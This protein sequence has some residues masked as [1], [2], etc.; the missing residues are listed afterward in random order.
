MVKVRQSMTAM[1]T[2][3]EDRTLVRTQESMSPAV[4]AAAS[5]SAALRASTRGYWREMDARQARHL[6]PWIS[7]LTKGMSSNHC[8]VWPQAMQ[9]EWER[10]NSSPRGMRK[11]STLQKLPTH[12]PKTAQIR[13]NMTGMEKSSSP[14]F[15]ASYP[16]PET[17][18]RGYV[19][20][21]LIQRGIRW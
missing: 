12:R 19:G 21:V 11:M 18:G 8:R 6:P 5:Q 9:W 1:H 15:N 2:K 10:T 3:M 14:H 7:Q 20:F 13:K 16:R 4:S 17:S